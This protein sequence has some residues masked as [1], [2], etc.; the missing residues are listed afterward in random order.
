M[1]RGD[2]SRTTAASRPFSFTALKRERLPR[3]RLVVR[4][5]V[6]VEWRNLF[7]SGGTPDD[8]VVRFRNRHVEALYVWTRS[9]DTTDENFRTSDNIVDVRL[10]HVF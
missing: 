5:L 7:Y 6:R 3:H 9:R 8:S 2:A 10:K 4:N 1:M